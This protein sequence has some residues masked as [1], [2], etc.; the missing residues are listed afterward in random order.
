LEGRDGGIIGVG[1][2]EQGTVNTVSS[3][4][5]NYFGSIH[6]N[7]ATPTVFK[8]DFIK[9]R[10]IILNYQIP[11]SLLNKI[12]V[13]GATIGLVARNVAILMKKTGNLDPESNY[14]NS[15]AQG[16]EYG[17]APT[18]RNIGINLNIKF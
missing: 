8:S 4:S 2:N 9:L 18:T 14:N 17:S 7:I 16:L 6:S 11:S 15:N 3:T 5:Q 13:K 10:Q 12:N 1:V